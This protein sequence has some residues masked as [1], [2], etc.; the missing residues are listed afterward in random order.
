MYHEWFVDYFQRAVRFCPMIKKRVI[1]STLTEP[2]TFFE[3]SPQGFTPQP[4]PQW[5]KW[6]RKLIS[7]L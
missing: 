6:Q 5:A 1:G 2:I 4:R 7:L 3:A